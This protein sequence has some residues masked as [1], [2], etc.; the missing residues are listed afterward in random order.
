LDDAIERYRK[1]A[2]LDPRSFVAYKFWGDTL[3]QQGKKEEAEKMLS[4]ASEVDPTL[5][6]N[7]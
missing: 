6:R 2:E 4:K 1:V 5:H 3:K 7:R